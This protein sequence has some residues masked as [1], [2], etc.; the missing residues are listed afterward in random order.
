MGDTAEEPKK[1]RSPILIVGEDAAFPFPRSYANFVLALNSNVVFV[2]DRNVVSLHGV[3]DFTTL[4]IR[5]RNNGKAIH[6]EQTRNIPLR[7]YPKTSG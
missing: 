1:N 3:R 7:N 6:D 2:L 4:T 5:E